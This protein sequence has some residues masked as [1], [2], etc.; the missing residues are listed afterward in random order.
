MDSLAGV[1]T[2]TKAGRAARSNEEDLKVRLRDAVGP[3]TQWSGLGHCCTLSHKYLSDGGYSV[4]G[5]EDA[6]M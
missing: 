3:N 6:M 5:G 1:S 4:D 2:V